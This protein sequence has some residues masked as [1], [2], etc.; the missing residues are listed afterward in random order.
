MRKFSIHTDK[1]IA[2]MDIDYLR[3]EF[4]KEERYLLLVKL[5]RIDSF[6]SRMWGEINMEWG[7]GRQNKANMK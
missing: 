1:R 3:R 6:F 5:N 2:E 4:E 7:K